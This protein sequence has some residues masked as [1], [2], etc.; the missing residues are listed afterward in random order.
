LYIG[1]EGELYGD[2]RLE[3]PFKKLGCDIYK[4]NEVEIE[5]HMR[6]YDPEIIP[7]NYGSLL[8]ID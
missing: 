5:N 4:M 1:G 2:D 3:I 6:K 7:A 8:L